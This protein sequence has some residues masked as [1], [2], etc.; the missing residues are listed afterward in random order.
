MDYPRIYQLPAVTEN[1][2]ATIADALRDYA[3]KL[4]RYG[5]R[6]QQGRSLATAWRIRADY[7]ETLATRIDPR[8]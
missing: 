2:A 4:R 7:V 1:D 8:D 5:N 6:L 3:K